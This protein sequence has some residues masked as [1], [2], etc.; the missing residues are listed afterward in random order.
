MQALEASGRIYPVLVAAALGRLECCRYRSSLGVREDP[1]SAD[2]EFIALDT[3]QSSRSIAVME[4][5]TRASGSASP[6]P[7]PSMTG[8]GVSNIDRH[9][10]QEAGPK[11]AR[12][13]TANAI[14][15]CTWSTKPARPYSLYVTPSALGHPPRMEHVLKGSLARTRRLRTRSSRSTNTSSSITLSCSRPCSP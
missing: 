15:T 11:P 2:F 1:E 3:Q 14:H 6:P 4:A 7:H 10:T 13:L 8:S 12:Y 9:C 5:R